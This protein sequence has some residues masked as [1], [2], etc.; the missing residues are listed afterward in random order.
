[1]ETEHS[2]KTKT[3]KPSGRLAGMIEGR[4]LK[5][6]ESIEKQ[7]AAPDLEV[8]SE[9]CRRIV[10]KTAPP[11]NLSYTKQIDDGL[12]E[13][14]ADGVFALHPY[15][16]AIAYEENKSRRAGATVWPDE[17]FFR[18]AFF[19]PEIVNVYESLVDCYGEKFLS[20]DN[21]RRCVV[22]IFEITGLLTV[23][24]GFFVGS[25]EDAALFLME[26]QNLQRVSGAIATKMKGLAV[27]QKILA[28]ANELDPEKKM[29]AS[30]IACVLEA[31]FWINRKTKM[32]HGKL[33]TLKD[34]SY[35]R[36][37]FKKANI[38]RVLLKNGWQNV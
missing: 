27:K 9:L 25:F 29:T 22:D 28:A 30:E 38:Q 23:W 6:L 11:L 35:P 10:D 21:S 7:A 3:L 1:M 12:F 15:F 26:L 37:S 34:T 8:L 17:L 19:L 24:D 14:R 2:R 32:A 5:L 33:S 13:A 31:H 18:T 4:L 16:F 20:K 36:R